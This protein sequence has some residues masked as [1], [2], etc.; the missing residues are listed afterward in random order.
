M[1]GNAMH[2]L[3]HMNETKHSLTNRIFITLTHFHKINENL[4]ARF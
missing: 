4:I 3:S 1:I 2:E